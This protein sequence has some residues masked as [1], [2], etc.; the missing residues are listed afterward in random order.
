MGIIDELDKQIELIK[1][2]RQ[3][4]ISYLRNLGRAKDAELLESLGKSASGMFKLQAKTLKELRVAAIMDQF[5]LESYRPECQLLELTPEHWKQEITEFQPELLFIES[6]W[7][8]KDELWYRK[9]DRSS[10][11]MYELTSYCHDKNIPVIFWNKEDPIYTSQFMTTAALADYV[12]TTDIDC[13]KRYKTEL[14]RDQVYHLHFAAQP[15]LHN[16]LEKY[17]RKDKFCFAGAYY[18]RYPHRAEVFDKFAEVFLQTKGFDIYDRN[19]GNARPEHAFPE[20]YNP[21]ILGSLPSSQIDVAYKGYVYGVNMNS[22]QQSQTM[23]ARRA[24]EMLASNT[25]TVGNYSRGMKN[26]FGDLTIC[27]DDK[28]TLE[29]NLALYCADSVTADKYRLAGLRKVL[30]EHLYEDRLD[31]IVQKVFGV[32]L[33]RPLPVI[34]MVARY[35]SDDELSYLRSTYLKQSYDDKVLYLIGNSRKDEE[36]GIIYLTPQEAREKLC[37]DEEGIDYY[38]CICSDDYY[39]KNYLLDLALTLRYGSYDVIGKA[40]YYS[41]QNGEFNKVSEGKPYTAVSRLIARR[42]VVSGSSLEKESLWECSEADRIYDAGS[43]LAVDAFNYCEAYTQGFCEAVDDLVIYDQGLALEKIEKVAESIQP[44][45][46]DE[47]KTIIISAKELYECIRSSAKVKFEMTGSDLKIDACLEEGIHEYHYCAKKYPILRVV[48]DGKM[49]VK[50]R[51]EGVLDCVCVCICYNEKGEKTGT[52]FPKLNIS[53][54]IEIPEGTSSIQIGFRPKGKGTLV[55]HGAI[56][57]NSAC[58]ADQKGCFLARTGVLVLS[59]QY[60]TPE[61][62]YRNMFVHKRVTCYKEAGRL[63]DVMRMN[64]F[65]EEAYREFEGVNIVDGS[66]RMLSSVMESGQIHAVCV[67]FLDEMMWNVLKDYADK[68]RIYVWLHG[69][70]IQPWWRREYNYHNKEQLEKAK[71]ESEVRMN[72]W[73]GIFSE[74]AHYPKLHFIVVSQYFANEIFEDNKITLDKKRY[75]IIHNCIDTNLFRY[76]PKPAEQRKKLLSIRPYASDKY[77]ND[78]TV[79]CILELAKKPYFEELEFR[80]IGNGELFEST[81]K[82]LQKYKNVIIEKRFLRQDEIAALHREYGIFLTPTRMDAQGVSRDEA[83]AGGL[84]PVTNAVTAIPEFTDETCAIL[85]PA[86]DYKAMAAGIERVIQDEQLFLQMSENAAK[87]VRI[88]SAP[89]FTIDQEIALIY[90]G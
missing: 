20:R 43:L 56:L 4:T 52:Q 55:V 68:V 5:T 3:S 82:P 29:K 60:P 66:T 32:S 76:I 34:A 53:T 6:A 88:Q 90:E 79:K 42:S 16:P 17:D 30:S 71:K 31:F 38:A 78:L 44:V 57:G 28:Q 86:E 45:D 22:V 33:K 54:A 35:Q 77:A 87:R 41:Q 7:K 9:V 85:A 72:F 63:C 47:D 11:E 67:H 40:D 8:G 75:S 23:F 36:Q 73:S 48:E 1:K 65:V 24:F 21:C 2:R 83:M 25:I 62:L 12:F 64:P 74:L 14:G 59:N 18:H 49:D 89:E 15:R 81:L 69:S 84:I 70:E 10:K 58:D 46:W 37:R 39:G 26:Y 13:V 61:S 80:L 27:T 19:Y 51:A 50:V